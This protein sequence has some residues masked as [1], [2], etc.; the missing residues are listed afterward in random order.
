MPYMKKQRSQLKL[1]KDSS[2]FQSETG[3][4]TDVLENSFMS[5]RSTICSTQVVTLVKKTEETYLKWFGYAW[6]SL[7]KES[8]LNQG[9]YNCYYSINKDLEGDREKL[10]TK[11]LK[12]IQRSIIC[13]QRRFMILSMQ[14]S[15]IPDLVGKGNFV[16]VVARLDQQYDLF[17]LI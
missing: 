12:N 17:W 10:Y 15:S 3:S 1:L 8:R 9:Q 5:F 11:P 13:S 4:N 7:S 16:I 2:D 6:R 14:Q